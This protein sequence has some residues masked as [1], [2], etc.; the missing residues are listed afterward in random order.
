MAD[1]DS[2]V[3]DDS[4]TGL[5]PYPETALEHAVKMLYVGDEEGRGNRGRID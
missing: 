4:A 5:L 2:P 1:D 3:K